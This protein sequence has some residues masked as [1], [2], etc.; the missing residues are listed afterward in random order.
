MSE[1]VKKARRRG[2]ALLDAI[3]A[4]VSAELAEVGF[5]MTDQV[6]AAPDQRCDAHR[7]GA[8]RDRRPARAARPGQAVQY[9]LTS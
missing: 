8:G 6:L 4:A 1:Q 3:Y 2:R 7:R 5:R 9:S